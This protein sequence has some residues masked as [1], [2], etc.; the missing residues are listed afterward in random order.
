MSGTGGGGRTASRRAGV[1]PRETAVGS[2]GH[3][4]PGETTVFFCV[5]SAHPARVCFTGTRE[6]TG[7]RRD[8]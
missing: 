4:L 5:T 7:L 3:C 2:A 8:S 6:S 1:V